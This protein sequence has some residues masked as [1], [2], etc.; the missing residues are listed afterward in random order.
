MRKFVV[1]ALLAALASPMWANDEPIAEKVTVKQLEERL[2]AA[3]GRADAEVAQQLSG[4][5][6]SERLSAVRFARLN[7]GL[8]GE[9]AQLALLILA[10]SAA[11]LDPPA[12]EIPASPL[13]DPAATRQMMTAIVNYVNTTVR[14]LPNLMAMRNT[15]GF[16]DRPK[17]DVQESTGMISYSYLPLHAVGKS[18]VRVTYRD[19]QEVADE[20]TLKHGPKIGG[21]ATSG[22]FG[23]ILSMVVGDA[24]KGKITWNRWEQGADGKEAVFHYTVPGD[25]SHYNVQFCCV[26][27]GFNSD[28]SPN[29]RVFS[30]RVGYHGDLAF[31]PATG[32]IL[33]ITMEAELPAGDL[34]SKAG[35]A[36]EY[37]P[38]EIGGRTYIC[39]A[40]SAS[41]LLAN[42]AQHVGAYSRS[43]YQG[44]AKTFLNDVVFDQYRRFGTESRILPVGSGQTSAPASADAPYSAP[45]RAPTH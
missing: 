45:S 17:E 8:P 35:I 43:N 25:K 13:P 4:L 20:K 27:D 30:E 37:S 29:V 7:A 44:A 32:S 16:E 23:P 9:K 39:P 3:H 33:R 12:A 21:L 38:V 40:K 15:T 19:R 2:A 14:Q 1:L 31:D 36:V 22:E 6:L 10:D 11:F 18:S 42:I 34:V 28:G 26:S 5:E 41:V 24:L